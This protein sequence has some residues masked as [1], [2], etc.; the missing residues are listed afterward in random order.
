MHFTDFAP[1]KLTCA[2]VAAQQLDL[3]LRQTSRSVLKLAVQYTLF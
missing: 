1:W 2:E 3:F